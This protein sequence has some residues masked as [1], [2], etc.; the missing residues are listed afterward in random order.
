[1]RRLFVESLEDRRLLSLSPQLVADINTVP[2]NQLIPTEVVEVGSIAYFVANRP[3]VST[4]WKSDGTASGT[5]PVSEAVSGVQFLTNVNGTLFFQASDGSHGNELWKSDGTPAGTVMLKDIQPGL[6]N[7]SPALLTNVNGTLFFTAN[8]GSHGAELWKSDGTAA[9]TVMVKDIRPGTDNPFLTGLTNVDGTLFFQADFQLWKSNGTAAGTV[10]IKDF[11][12]GQIFSAPAYLTNVNG[13][14]FF[15]ANDGT[16]GTELWKSDGTEAGTVMVKDIWS[17]AYAVYDSMPRHLTNVGGTLFFKATDGVHGPELWKSDGTAEG[18]V[19][20][21]DT[22]SG[23]YAY[24]PVNLTNVG[25]TLFFRA[26][27]DVHGGELWKSDGTEAGTVMLKDIRPGD[28][29]SYPSGLTNVNGTLFFTANDG[30]HGNELWKSDGTAAGT[31]MVND[32]RPGTDNPYFASL[33]NVNG[34]LFFSATS[35][36]S[37]PDLWKSDGTAAGTVRVRP[38]TASSYPGLL[39]NVGGTLFFAANDGSDEFQLWKSDGTTAGT[40]LV[41]HVGP[42]RSWEDLSPNDWA[43][44]N[45]TL[46]FLANDGALGDELWKSNGTEAGTVMVKDIF[47]G[48]GGSH[49]GVAYPGYM[50]GSG[51][52]N[53]NGTLFFAANDDA[54]GTELWKSDGTAAGTVLVADICPNAFGSSPVELTNVNGTLFFR[55]NDGTHGDELW[56]SD[57]T[58]A[59][60]VRVK[61]TTPGERLSN[62][63]GLTNVNGALFFS[64]IGASRT[65]LWKSDGTD[66]GTVLVKQSGEHYIHAVSRA[67]VNGTL[68][69][70]SGRGQQP[71]TTGIELW[72]SDGTEA[73]TVMVKDILP[74]LRGS[75][76]SLLTNVNGTLFFRAQDDSNGYELWKSDGTAAGTVMVKD[77]RP[78]TGSSDPSEL[79]NFNGKLL[80]GASDGPN[81]GELWVSDGTAAG[82]VMVTNLEQVNDGLPQGLTVVGDTMFFSPN[83]A[84]FGRELWKVQ[85]AP[86]TN[87]PTPDPST[88]ATEPYATGRNS[89]KMVATTAADPEGSG[90]EYYFQ[91]L[92]S[93]GHDSAWQSSPTYEDT[94]LAAGTA[95]T[96]QVKTRDGSSNHNEGSYSEPKSATTLLTPDTTPPTSL[97]DALPAYQNSRTFTV[98]WS[99]S[100]G[101]QGSGIA[102]YSVYVS[103][104]GGKFKAWR[105]NTTETSA[106]FTGQNGHRYGFYSV[107][108]DNAG[109]VQ[110]RPST[111]Q[112]VTT[113]DVAA[114]T[115]SLAAHKVTKTGTSYSFTVTY[116]DKWGVKVA[117]LGDANILVT[118]PQGFSQLATLVKVDKLSNGKL[119]R[120]TY[121]ISPPGGS[122]D[123]A[124]NGVYA[125]TMQAGQVTDLAGNPVAPRGLGTFKVAVRGGGALNDSSKKAAAFVASG[126]TSSTSKRRSVAGPPRDAADRAAMRSIVAPRELDAALAEVLSAGL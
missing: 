73:G 2:V 109:N 48:S 47:P 87:P 78:G 101:A 122:W 102:T 84:F 71:D 66:A 50:Y 59:G 62:P 19:L 24:G 118:G 52:T 51:L 63:Y 104:N 8:D 100:D 117:T 15:S 29:F 31:V 9:G 1:V 3:S 4:L 60:T 10:M 36:G 42:L 18:T 55:A 46:F 13:L 68:Y 97:V 74:G 95:Y 94:G 111:A 27:D 107:A 121:R 38:S 116:K 22:R 12:P 40:A 83:D 67:T 41:K 103:D 105:S 91:C 16:Y 70:A 77:I 115:A 92:T 72:K 86:D 85:Q 28:A 93:G 37:D 43:N 34:T 54:H 20:V 53:V 112:A 96:Y 26:D 124:D 6:S 45:G 90:V 119:R 35:G 39:T 82:T 89:I 76:P 126:F 113:V 57:G 88:W 11:L 98:S 32:I 30:S 80:F 99:G 61:T 120:A 114:P 17:G 123:A 64:A 33:T 14:L 110:K 79:T 21:K 25:G 75:N 44:V 58:S 106:A 125:V 49:P 5:A 108:K 23:S 56:K 69:F 81:N 7:S 65:G